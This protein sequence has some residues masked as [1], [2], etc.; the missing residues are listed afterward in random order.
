MRDIQ[1][2]LISRQLLTVC[3]AVARSHE[4]KY[5]EVSAELDHNVDTLLVGVVKQIRLWQLSHSAASRPK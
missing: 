5:V 2:C 1:I 4:V 3:L